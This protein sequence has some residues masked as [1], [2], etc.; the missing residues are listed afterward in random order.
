MQSFHPPAHLES[1]HPSHRPRAII[2]RDIISL[3]L[4]NLGLGVVLKKSI[5][6]EVQKHIIGK[7]HSF[8]SHHPS[9]K[10]QP[11]SSDEKEKE[12]FSANLNQTFVLF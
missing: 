5:V 1:I 4:G 8:G 9:V 6:C 7:R 3:H 10:C 2:A 12:A 11:G